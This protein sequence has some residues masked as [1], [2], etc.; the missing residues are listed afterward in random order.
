MIYIDIDGVAIDFAGTLERRFG[1]KLEPSD[2][3]TF[4][5]KMRDVCYKCCC[6]NLRICEDELLEER[7]GIC[8]KECKFPTP[9]EFYAKAELMPWVHDLLLYTPKKTLLTNDNVRIKERRLV[10]LDFVFYGCNIIEAPDKSIHCKHPCDIL[11]DD[12]PA[13]CEAWR[14]KG[15]LAFWFDCSK[16]DIFE[17]FL[18]WWRLENV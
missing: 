15:G 1:I 17:Q 14:K 8:Y 13:E 9:Q 18:K 16:P 11:L 2:F 4:H 7:K 6:E 12:N 3:D 10:Q 5:W